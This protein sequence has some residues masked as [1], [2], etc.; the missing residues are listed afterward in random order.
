MHLEV[1]RSIKKNHFQFQGIPS[2]IL[3]W[4]EKKETPNQFSD[5]DGLPFQAD[6]HVLV[7]KI[8]N[9]HLQEEKRGI[10]RTQQHYNCK[11]TIFLITALGSPLFRCKNMEEDSLFHIYIIILHQINPG[12]PIYPKLKHKC[13]VLI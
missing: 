6:P 2:H 12:F 13:V 1:Y 8:C 3:E 9:H 10:D 7:L 5:A 11:P 4:R